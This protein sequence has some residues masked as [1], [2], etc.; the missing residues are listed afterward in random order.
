MQIAAYLLLTAIIHN[1]YLKIRDRIGLNSQAI[2]AS[3]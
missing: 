3:R 1:D 2:E